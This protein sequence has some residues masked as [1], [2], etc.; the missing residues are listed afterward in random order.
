MTSLSSQPRLE[1][2]GRA[3]GRD[4]SRSEQDRR[5]AVAL[6]PER[7]L[8]RGVEADLVL[9]GYGE[10]SA[11]EVVKR[12]NKAALRRRGAL[13][14]F[15]IEIQTATA[16][17]GTGFLPARR[18]RRGSGEMALVMP[19][20]DGADLMTFL[21]EC[22]RRGRVPKLDATIA[23]ALQMTEAL[24]QLHAGPGRLAPT[25]HGA[26]EAEN[27]LLTRDGEAC[28]IDFGSCRA[29]DD[30]PSGPRRDLRAL[31]ELLAAM[32]EGVLPGMLAEP[33]RSPR[34]GG[35]GLKAGVPRDVALDQIISRFV[36]PPEVGG[37]PTARAARSALKSLVDAS[38]SFVSGPTLAAEVQLVMG[39]QP[40]ARA[41]SSR[42]PFVPMIVSW[43]PPALKSASAEVSEPKNE[44]PETTCETKELVVPKAG[45]DRPGPSERPWRPAEGRSLSRPGS[46]R[47]HVD[48]IK[49]TRPQ[50]IRPRTLPG[51]K[52]RTR[53]PALG[54][55]LF[56]ALAF[57]GAL[58]FMIGMHQGRKVAAP[59]VLPPATVPVAQAPTATTPVVAA[60]PA[61]AEKPVPEATPQAATE[62]PEP[63]AVLTP[64]RA[65]VPRK[66]PT[67]Q[68]PG[69]QS[70]SQPAVSRKPR[71]EPAARTEVERVPAPRPV[72]EPSPPR[73]PAKGV[74]SAPEPAFQQ[75]RKGPDLV[76]YSCTLTST[77][78]GARISQNGEFVGTTPLTLEVAEGELVR[79]SAFLEGHGE[80][81]R[82][83]RA[84]EDGGVNFDLTN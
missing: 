58:L 69:R 37:F 82:K 34:D 51:R 46:T 54:F 15:L 36:H 74:T 79:F 47:D 43:L 17:E 60:A 77:P 62:A 35:P 57:G 75:V 48:G 45:W 13:R 61:T 14:R 50:P 73:A 4:T 71:P 27:I 83:W 67:S 49:A 81:G 29:L 24:A 42:P 28:L 55:L 66:S 33:I 23:V 19:W 1:S 16:V 6:R 40:G 31:G 56:F 12:L 10:G 18:I 72:A 25:I 70:K 3:A 78:P 59:A 68:P 52:L 9:T 20:V 44:D 32:R 41:R 2:E 21:V 5:R 65:P 7:M 64:E 63:R 8:A 30:L 26:V 22:M 39:L 38:A 84:T 53:K 76:T 80:R 11:L